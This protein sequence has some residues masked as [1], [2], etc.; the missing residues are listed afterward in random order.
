MI[1]ITTRRAEEA[2][3]CAAV[4]LRGSIHHEPKGRNTLEQ[5]L[6]H[7]LAIMSILSRAEG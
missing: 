6:L 2:L 1:K 7:S 4:L 5:V 3:F